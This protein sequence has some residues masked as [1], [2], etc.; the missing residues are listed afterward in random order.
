MSSQD[1]REIVCVCIVV[2]GAYTFMLMLG[3]RD[4]FNQLKRLAD[5]AEG[6]VKEGA[7]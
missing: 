2:A 7:E 6:K 5:H 3:L 4:I 1:V